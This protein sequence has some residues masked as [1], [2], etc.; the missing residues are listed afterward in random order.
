M[1]SKYEPPCVCTECEKLKLSEDF[2]SQYQV[3][4]WHIASGICTVCV[5]IR[6]KQRRDARV[7]ARGSAGCPDGEGQV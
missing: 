1:Q 5:R 3:K 6:A 4:R 7:K 2:P